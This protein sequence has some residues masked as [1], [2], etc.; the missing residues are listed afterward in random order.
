[1]SVGAAA[2]IGCR[3][4][5]FYRLLGVV[6]FGAIGVLAALTRP[7]A[8]AVDALTEQVLA[9]MTEDDLQRQ[10]DTYDG[11]PITAPKS[12]PLT[13]SI[14]TPPT[15]ADREAQSST[16]LPAVKRPWLQPQAT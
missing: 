14:A 16:T 15:S 1:M 6:L 12:E 7:A 13:A 2:V 5:Y 3:V 8:E 9:G 4:V 11:E 10:V